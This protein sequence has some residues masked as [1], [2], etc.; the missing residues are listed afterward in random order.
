M[1]AKTRGCVYANQQFKTANAC[2]PLYGSVMQFNRTDE[3]QIF[4]RIKHKSQYATKYSSTRKKP[5]ILSLINMTYRTKLYQ[6]L[7]QFCS[8]NLHFTKGKELIKNKD[9]FSDTFTYVHM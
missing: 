6:Y 4:T 3:G 8:S 1:E 2:T 9:R 5:S 7:S